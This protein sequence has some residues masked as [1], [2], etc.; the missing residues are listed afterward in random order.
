MRSSSSASWRR[1]AGARLLPLLLAALAGACAPVT[2]RPID[3]EPAAPFRSGSLADASDALSIAVPRAG[4]LPPGAVLEALEYSG[5]PAM[6]WVVQRFRVGN[7]IVY[8]LAEQVP[9]EGITAT[10]TE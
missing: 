1:R 7:G 9:P 10:V 2:P 8:L 4:Y 3:T 5:D 6:P